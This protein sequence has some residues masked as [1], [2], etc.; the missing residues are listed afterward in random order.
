LSPVGTTLGD[1]TFG[2]HRRD[3]QL[4]SRIVGRENEMAGA[5]LDQCPE[6]RVAR[7][8]LKRRFATRIAASGSRKGQL[9]AQVQRQRNCVGR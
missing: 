4:D 1:R 9:R 2:Q 3:S 5:S 8:I 6:T 7:H